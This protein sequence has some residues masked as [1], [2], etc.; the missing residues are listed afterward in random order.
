MKKTFTSIFLVLGLLSLA[1]AQNTITHDLIMWTTGMH[2][3]WDG[4]QALYYGFGEGSFA[5][6]QFPGPILYANEGDTMVINVRN[7]SQGAP[8]TIHWHGLDVDQEN[9]G[10]P[11]TSY[12]IYHQEDTFYKFVA[13]HAGTYLYHCHVASVV[14]VQLGMYGTVII[15]PADGGNTAWTGGP[16]YSKEYNWLMSEFDKTWHDS[17]PNHHAADT[18]LPY[19]AI[20]PYIPDYFMVNGQSRQQLSDTNTAVAA[21]VGEKVYLRLSNI[22]FYIN[23]IAFPS[24]LDAQI[25]SSDGRPL[26]NSL[27]QDTLWLTPGERYGV[28]LTPSIEL[29]DSIAVSY[30]NPNTYQNW[31]TEQVPLSING[32]VGLPEPESRELELSVFPNPNRGKF[33][34]LNHGV[35]G[36]PL[37]I[38]VIDMQGRII[39]EMTWGNPII[40]GHFEVTLPEIPAGIYSLK[41][42]T[43][44][45]SSRTKLSI[46]K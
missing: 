39:T 45:G 14:H 30:I 46:S 40:G 2:T 31:N 32:I 17:V 36:T 1:Q 15:R 6:P 12:V 37:Q 28:M 20:P 16:S 23:K 34:L 13:P 38:E 5:P 22:G 43:K 18:S 7:Q 26:P 41:C 4:N 21:K 10:V 27:D 25:I 44:T 19:F 33:T 3:L 29:D 35:T 24:H 9:D 8:H 11:Q 42:R